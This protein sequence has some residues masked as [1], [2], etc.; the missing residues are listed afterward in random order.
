MA[1]AKEERAA[2]VDA[3]ESLH[4][5]LGWGFHNLGALFLGAMFPGLNYLAGVLFGLVNPLW[6]IVSGI[7]YFA[8]RNRLENG[9]FSGGARF[10]FFASALNWLFA[11]VGFFVWR[12]ILFH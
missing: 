10:A 5:V 8:G 7:C 6:P 4:H 11:I 1:A 2:L 9:D 3:S 12:A